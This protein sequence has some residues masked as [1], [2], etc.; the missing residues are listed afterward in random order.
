MKFG[1]LTEYNIKK[2]FLEKSY[3]KCSGV[4]IPRP[5]PKNKNW[6]S[7]WVNS[8]N[9]YTACFYCMQGWRLW[10]YIKLSCRPLAFISCQAFFLFFFL[11]KERS[12][13][14]LPVSFS[15]SILR[16][17]M[18]LFI[19]YYQTKFRCL[20]KLTLSDIVQYVYCNCVLTRLSCHWSK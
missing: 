8:Q 20:V 18:S 5:F 16:K 3:T 19:L 1:Q 10:K 9:F 17:N 6:A 12:R 13:T 14:T 15:Q 7:L 4:T 2:V 11:K